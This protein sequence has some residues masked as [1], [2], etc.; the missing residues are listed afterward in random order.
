MSARG[1]Q[2]ADRLVRAMIWKQNLPFSYRRHSC[3]L[4]PG[5]AFRETAELAACNATVRHCSHSSPLGSLSSEGAVDAASQ[6]TM[7][8]FETPKPWSAMVKA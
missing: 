5:L 6:R 3:A 7:T 1:G 8:V 4:G 2:E